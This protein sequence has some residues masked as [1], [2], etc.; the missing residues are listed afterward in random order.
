MPRPRY[1]YRYVYWWARTPNWH[2][3]LDE[4]RN[5]E[6]WTAI[7]DYR[8]AADG[9]RVL[10][11]HGLVATTREAHRVSHALRRLQELTGVA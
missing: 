11:K 2:E 5:N 7:R 3:K 8:N 6:L 9:I 10:T 1:E 4:A